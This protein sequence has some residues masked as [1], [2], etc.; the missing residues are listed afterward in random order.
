MPV[1]VAVRVSIESTAVSTLA[2]A[3]QTGTVHSH[4][5][6]HLEFPRVCVRVRNL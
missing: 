4:R 6:M 3:L 5:F 2:L 1:F